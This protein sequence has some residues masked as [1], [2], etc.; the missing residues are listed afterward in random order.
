MKHE[1]ETNLISL[2]SKH[3][4]ETIKNSSLK[5]EPK[6][7]MFLNAINYLDNFDSDNEISNLWIYIIETEKNPIFSIHK[8]FRTTDFTDSSYLDMIIW[9]G[10]QDNDI[11]K[12][13]S[14]I[15]NFIIKIIKENKY[16][17]KVDN[18]VNKVY[19]KFI[20]EEDF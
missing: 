4:V 19:D 20:F 15:F 10:L 9:N 6:Y 3:F 11:N 12:E 5:K 13:F 17:K 7:S 2:I 1:I 14:K 16:N 18:Y 8:L